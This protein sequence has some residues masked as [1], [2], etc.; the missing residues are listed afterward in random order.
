[1]LSPRAFWDE[2][3]VWEDMF[4]LICINSPQNRSFHS[5]G[6]VERRLL[7]TE[8]ALHSAQR[9]FIK[10]AAKPTPTDNKVSTQSLVG[11]RI[12]MCFLQQLTAARSIRRVGRVHSDR[13]VPDEEC[14]IRY[15]HLSWELPLRSDTSHKLHT[16]WKCSQI[17]SAPHH[18]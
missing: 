15:Q 6:A 4:A 18:G 11:S 9:S 12:W 8:E 14:S 17:W 7:T 2:W 10:L 13:A 1:M 16:H 5:V 3:D